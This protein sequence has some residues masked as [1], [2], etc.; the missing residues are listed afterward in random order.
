MLCNMYQYVVAES[1]CA[2]FAQPKSWITKCG[3]KLIYETLPGKEVVYILPITSILGRLPIVRAGDTGTI[4]F[5]CWNGFCN[6]A[7]RYNNTT[8]PGLTPRQGVVIDVPYSLKIPGRWAGPATG[9]TEVR[10]V[11]E[12]CFE[13]L[14]HIVFYVISLY[15]IVH[16]YNF[17][18]IYLHSFAILLLIVMVVITFY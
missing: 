11:C 15:Y 1:K 4:P 14:L 9:E 8:S 5:S 6:G 2:Y 7:H 18:S 17:C 16:Y 13:I 3:S 10:A 12:K